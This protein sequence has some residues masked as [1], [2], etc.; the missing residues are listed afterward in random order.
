MPTRLTQGIINRARDVHP[1]GKQLYDSET[2]GLRVVV[3]RKSASYKLVT[4]QWADGRKVRSISVTLGRTDEI[5][6]KEARRLAVE[7][8]LE[9]RRGGDP[10]R[11]E[12]RSMTLDDAWEDY[13]RTRGRDLAPRTLDWMVKKLDARLRYLRN[14]PLRDFD[15][16]ELRDLHRRITEDGAPFEANGCMRVLKTL[17][18]HAAAVEDLPP[19]PVSRAIRMNK[20]RPRDWALSHDQI[21]DL[22]SRLEAMPNRIYAECWMLMLLTG[23]RS[24]SARS[25]RW[26]HIDDDGCLLVPRPK[27]GEDRA[28]RTPLSG[29]LLGRLER[30]RRDMA[31]FDSPFVFPSET[32]GCGHA[33]GLRRTQDLPYSPH[34]TRHTYRN[35]AVEAEVDFQS[36]A[37]LMN[38]SV[39]HVS[40]RYITRDKLMPTLRRAQ[41]SISEH[42]LGVVKAR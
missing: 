3:G 4:D 26:E 33:V 2:R 40:F 23:L 29:Y 1:P 27:G 24:A 15:R 21:R 35:A 19:N 38:H 13:R 32:S 37:L 9:I 11:R 42:L 30:H 39:P 36:I 22:W 28:F 31:P 20:E 17:Y 6:L 5:G 16:A 10:N 41:E 25:A 14:T 12:P 7:R 34:M 18:N 8:K